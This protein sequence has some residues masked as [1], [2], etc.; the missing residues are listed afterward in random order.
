MSDRKRERGIQEKERTRESGLGRGGER[1]VG[2]LR[3][4]E[5]GRENDGEKGKSKRREGGRQKQ[6]HTNQRFNSARVIGNDTLSGVFVSK[7]VAFFGPFLV[8]AYLY[9][10][11]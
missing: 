9:Y 4:K 5:M 3:E 10:T 11:P 2:R 6:N 7:C 8:F 1:K